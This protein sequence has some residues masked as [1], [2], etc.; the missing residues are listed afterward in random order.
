[1]ER[2]IEQCIST[3]HLSSVIERDPREKQPGSGC[4]DTD[5]NYEM[6][7][8]CGNEKQ[9]GKVRESGVRHGRICWLVEWV[10]VGKKKISSAGF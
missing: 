7:E 3:A 9:N 2:Q 10:H 6:W 5:V 1:M 4:R 8:E